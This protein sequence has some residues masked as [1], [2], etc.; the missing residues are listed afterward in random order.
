M[1]GTVEADTF[2]VTQQSATTTTAGDCVHTATSR[3]AFAGEFDA[4]LGLTGEKVYELVETFE[5]C[6]TGEDTTTT[7]VYEAR[8]VHLD[9]TH[10]RRPRTRLSWGYL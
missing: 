9:A 2:E 10:D 1:V 7:L 5:G 6:D 8:G 4:D 3:D